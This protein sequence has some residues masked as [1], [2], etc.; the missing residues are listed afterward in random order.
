MQSRACPSDPNLQRFFR[1]AAQGDP[2]LPATISRH[3]CLLIESPA[4]GTGALRQIAR[5]WQLSTILTMTSGAPLTVTSG[6]DNALT[7]GPG[8][9]PIQIAEAEIDSPTINRWFNR[10]AYIPNP[11]GLWGGIGRGTLR[12]PMNWN[13]DMSLSRRIQFGEDKRVGLRAES[14]SLLNRF[15]PNDP[16]TTL[17][18]ANFGKITSAQDPRIMQFALKYVF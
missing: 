1:S 7:G 15:R 12:G 9:R 3:A 2:D 17:S 8:Q 4:I 10:S 6:P 11:P 16:N 14:F 18:N 5:N 13:I